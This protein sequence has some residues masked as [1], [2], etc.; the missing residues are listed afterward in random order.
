MGLCGQRQ[1]GVCAVSPKYSCYAY[2]INGS[3][4]THTP[5]NEKSGQ[6]AHACKLIL[7]F[8]VWERFK[9]L[10][11]VGDQYMYLYNKSD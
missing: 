10:I 3:W 6:P 9:A 5:K 4:G 1:P 2:F 11:F 7:Y 8:P